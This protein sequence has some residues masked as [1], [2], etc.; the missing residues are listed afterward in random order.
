MSCEHLFKRNGVVLMIKSVKYEQVIDDSENKN[1]DFDRYTFE[2]RSQIA[3]KETSVIV[4]FHK[5]EISG[6]E[7][8]YGSWYDIEIEDCIKLLNTL[9]PN[10]IKRDFSRIINLYIK[11]IS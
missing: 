8:A 4:D 1:Y 5:N 7:I 9:N 3:T 10:D 6:D 11:N 2:T